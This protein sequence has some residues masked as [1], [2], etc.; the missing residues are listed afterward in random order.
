MRG[1]CQIFLNLL[2]NHQSEIFEATILYENICVKLKLTSRKIN[3]FPHFSHLKKV[4]LIPKFKEC[5]KI[6]K[7]FIGI[8]THEV[9][10]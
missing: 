9:Q 4:P 1:F 2:K 7:S 8:N 5:M 6:Q 10:N 3:L